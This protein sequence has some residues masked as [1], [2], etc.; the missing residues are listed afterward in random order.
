V[1]RAK[2]R[3]EAA[4]RGACIIERGRKL[5]LR[6][7][8]VVGNEDGH[9]RSHCDLSGQVPEGAGTA[10]DEAA[11]M[12]VEQ[13]GCGSMTSRNAPDSRHASDG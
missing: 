5:V 4:I 3:R 9:A 7:E 12:Q 10:V 13:R 8:P 1:P 2:L 11:T 6:R